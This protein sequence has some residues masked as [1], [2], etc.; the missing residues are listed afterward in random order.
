[1][2]AVVA[3]GNLEQAREALTAA[4]PDLVL[5]DMMLPDGRG[6]ELAQDL[7][8]RFGPGAPPLVLLSALGDPQEKAAGL[9][10]GA[11]DYIVKPFSTGELHARLERALRRAAERELFVERQRDALMMELHDGVGG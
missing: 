11:D 4:P 7:R 1:N 2:Y 10:A 8:E 5:S 6:S 9:L 3:A